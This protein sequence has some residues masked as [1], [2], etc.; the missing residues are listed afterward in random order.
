[1]EEKGTASRQQ[2]PVK[3]GTIPSDPSLAHFLS[4]IRFPTECMDN[5]ISQDQKTTLG[6]VSGLT[7]NITLPG[8]Q[9]G[10][11]DLTGVG[12]GSDSEAIHLQ[13][14][15]RPTTEVLLTD[16]TVALPARLEATLD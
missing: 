5:W 8:L 2:R 10:P 4:G 1:M 9:G 6:H 3:N 12:K 15:L 13:T 16:H 11:S 14:R 7:W